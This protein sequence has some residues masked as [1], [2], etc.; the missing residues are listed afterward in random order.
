VKADVGTLQDAERA[1][2]KCVET[3]GGVDILVN[4]AVVNPRGTVI[5]TGE[6]EWNRVISVNLNAAFRFSKYDI[7]EMI[8][9]GGGSIVNIASV[10]GLVAFEN[11]AAYD[12]SKGGLVMLTRSMAVDHAKDKV[13]VNCIC[14]GITD[15]PMFKGTVSSYA[16]QEAFL[17]KAR[18]MHPLGRLGKPEDIAYAALFLASEESSFITGAILPVDGGY[19]IQ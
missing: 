19:I 7:P 9:R 15:T 17:E 1:V 8:R 5:T 13:R 11:E 2:K 16:N 14:P 6:E 12:A 18:K 10:N 3:F 4:N